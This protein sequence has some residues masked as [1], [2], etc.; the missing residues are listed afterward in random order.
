MKKTLLLCACLAVVLMT[1]LAKAETY[2]IGPEKSKVTF[3]IANKPPGSSSF[4]T[5]PG[6]F[7]DFSGTFMLDS[8]NTAKSSVTMEVKT[9]SVDTANQRRDD[10]LRNPD[11]F[12]AKEFPTM[13]FKSTSFEKTA[14]DTYKVTGNF[15]LLGKTKPVTVDFKSSGPGAGQAKFKIKRSEFGMKFRIPDT[16]D[17]VDITLD[18]VGNKK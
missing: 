10:H 9:A 8:Q 2:A 17:E 4:Q 1:S 5:V 11:F 14:A 12:K 3:K 18:I 16:A 7:K 15:T 6:S 13:T